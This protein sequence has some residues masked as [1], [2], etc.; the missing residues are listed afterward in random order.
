MFLN[1]VIERNKKLIDCAVQ[2]SKD[3]KI[4]PDS[5]VVDVD[6]FKENAKI[7][8]EEAKRLNIQLY[9][10][11]KQLGRNPYLA[12]ILIEM[13]YPGAV[14]VDYKEA[15]L[16][17]NYKIPICNVGHLVQ[18]P[19]YLIEEL[20]G[21]GVDYFTVFSIEK[22]KRINMY[23]KKHNRVQRLM[24]RVI[25]DCDLMYDGQKEGIMLK[26]LKHL[27]KDVLQLSNVKIEC[28]TV[29]PAILFD[30]ESRVFKETKNYKT[31]QR[32]IGILQKVGIQLTDINVPSATCT[33][34]ISKIKSLNGTIGEPG[35]GFTGT[36]P[37]HALLD[38]EE[39]T[40]V[41][42]VSEVSH[43][44]KNHSYF[45]GGGFYR[46]GHWKTA[47]IVKE[48]GDYVVDEV[49]LPNFECIDYYIGLKQNHEVGNIVIS[50]FRFQMFTSRSDVILVEGIQKGE[51]YV[52]YK[53]G[54]LGEML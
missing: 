30:H 51:P 41:V 5:F 4:R 21:Y 6:A 29:F 8:L 28:L 10:M 42:Y 9:F 24:L 49:I 14:V 38:L 40:A 15:E 36:T 54:P 34:S 23:A 44:F 32:A 20:I 50:S 11:L 37:G 39:K 53:Y 3:Y 31:L 22:I 48:N 27:A 1:K 13:G 45:F 47:Y 19:N 26:D 43:N 12:N 2:L 7:M 33:R 35:H 16:L 25:D 18:T 17:M 46:R 52:I